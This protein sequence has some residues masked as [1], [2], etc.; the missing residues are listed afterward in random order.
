MAC[1]CSRYNG[2]SDWLIFTDCKALFSRNA[3]GTI[4]GLQNKLWLVGQEICRTPN[5]QST[6]LADHFTFKERKLSNE[7]KKREFE[8]Q[9][10][11]LIP[12]RETLLVSLW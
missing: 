12:P 3:H 6:N 5:D 2:R 10:D 7:K 4:T 11:H 9:P 8:E 1:V